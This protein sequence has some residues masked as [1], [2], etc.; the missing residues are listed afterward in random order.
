M[1]KHISVSHN[2][3]CES[4]LHSHHLCYMVN[5]GLHLSDENYYQTLIKEAKF[6]CEVCGRGAKSENNLC[7]PLRLK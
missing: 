2:L 5:Q 4:N 7:Q 3:D 1:N 6:K